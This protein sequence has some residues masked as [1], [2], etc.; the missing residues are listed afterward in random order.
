[1]PET[2]DIIR[3]AIREARDAAGLSDAALA[4]R[5]EVHYGKL[6]MYLRGQGELRSDTINRL[7]VALGVRLVPAKRRRVDQTIPLYD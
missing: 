4:R 3:E 5:A 2:P 6:N 7:L 1:M